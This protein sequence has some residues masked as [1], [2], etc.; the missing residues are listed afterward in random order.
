[1]QNYSKA[2]LK[3]YDLVKENRL[4]LKKYIAEIQS[5]LEQNNA[6]VRKQSRTNLKNAQTGKVIFTPPQD[7]ETIQAL[8]D[9]WKISD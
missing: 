2:L 5:E 1:M 4:L 9:N 8:L 3:G 7:Y 6:G